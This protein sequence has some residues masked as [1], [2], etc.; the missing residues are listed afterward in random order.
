MPLTRSSRSLFVIA[1]LPGDEAML[2]YDR[3][4]IWKI[5]PKGLRAAVNLTNGYGRK[6][7]IV[8]RFFDKELN[9]GKPGSDMIITGFSEETK[10]N[11]F[12]RFRY[13]AP[14]DP[15]MITMGRYVYHAW[16]EL[17]A[18]M[19]PV[20]ARNA[21]VWLVQRMSATESPNCFWT[22]DF[23]TFHPVSNF[24]PEK[25]Y[26]WYTSEL[27]TF[28]TKD[29]KRTKAILYKP[30]NFDSTRQYPVLFN[31][32]EHEAQKLNNFWKPD[33][34][35][36]YYF[37][38]PMMVSRGYLVCVTDIHFTIGD[39]ASSI[40]N[41]VE[42]AGDYL[43]KL[44][45]IDSKRYGVNGGSFGGYGT[46]CLATFS[47]KFAAAVTISGM[48]DLFSG[49]GNVPGTKDEIIE[50][51]QLRMGASPSGDPQGYLRNSPVAFTKNATT[52]VLIVNTEFDGNVNVQQGIEF[53]ISLR[54]EGKRAWMLRYKNDG[55]GIF[56]DS[57]RR[58]LYTRM[59]Q[60]FDH[61]LQGAPA[62][63]WMTKGITANQT[64]VSS[65]FEY[66][67]EIDTPATGG[68]TIH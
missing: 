67:T 62:P 30:D 10:D 13:G 16:G 20:K 57:N 48:C 26:Q 5:D 4:D 63:V 44:P 59:N 60:F 22:K 39:P 15:E 25:K 61:Y 32:Y 6:N 52:P 8:F 1:W 24:Y 33:Y 66:D 56:D 9:K 36:N 23:K 55:H 11:G 19:S 43:A 34:M 68:V 14:K 37:N 27:F 65:G 46:A 2:V 17:V 38:Y 7:K 45:Y 41:A 31:Y 53:F 54:R 47:K 51:R 28:T 29:G 3:Y 58:D 21:D 64:G 40:V 35:D 49:Y 18:G 42:G 50:N 12:Y